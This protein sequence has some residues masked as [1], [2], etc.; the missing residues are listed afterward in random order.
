MSDMNRNKPTEFDS[1]FCLIYRVSGSCDGYAG[2][3]CHGKRRRSGSRRRSWGQGRC[4]AKRELDRYLHYYQR[5]HA[6]ASGQKF[7]EQQR[8]KTERRMVELQESSSSMTWI[9][10]Q[11]TGCKHDQKHV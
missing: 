1:C 3:C 11:V 5:Y 10:V 4:S 7:S 9:D 6:H 2:A 8:E